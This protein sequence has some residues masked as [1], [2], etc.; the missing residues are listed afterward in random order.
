VGGNAVVHQV[1]RF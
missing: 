1:F